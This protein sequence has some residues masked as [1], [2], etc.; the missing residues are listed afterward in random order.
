MS[1]SPVAEDDW[2]WTDEDHSVVIDVLANDIEPDH[3]PLV[4]SSHDVISAHGG[5]VVLNKGGSFDYKPRDGFIG[6]DVFTYT[7]GDGEREFGS[8][9]VNV[10]VGRDLGGI[11]AVELTD[12]NPSEGDLWYGFQT[13][14]Q[15]LVTLWAQDSNDVTITLYDEN[16][17]ELAVW[18]PG[19]GN[20]RL[21]Q[22]APEGQQFYFCLRGTDDGVNVHLANVIKRNTITINGVEYR[23]KPVRT[24]SFTVDGGNDRVVISGSVGDDTLWLYPHSA[25]LIGTGYRI[26]VVNSADITFIGGGGNDRAYLFDS[27]GDDTFVGSATSGTLYGNGFYNS[28]TG[29]D[30]VYAYATQGGYDRAFLYDSAGDD[31]FI[32]TPEYGKLYGNGFWNFAEGFDRVYAYATAGGNDRAFLYDSDGDDTFIGTPDYGKLHGNGFYNYAIDFDRVY[33][34]ATAGGNDRAKFFDS[35]GNDT[36]IGTPTYAKLHGDGFYNYAIDFESAYAYAREGGNDRAKF[37]D[38]AGNDTFVA[39]PDYAKLYGNGFYNYASDFESAY[40]YAREGGNDRAFLYDSA[41][42]DTLVAASSYA[43]FYGSG[44]YNYAT[45]FDLVRAYATRGGSDAK[46]VS[47]VDYVLATYGDHWRRG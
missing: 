31:T 16:L 39:T 14:R 37:F 7:A 10:V 45:G 30:H 47:A 21:E 40:A 19:N 6:T 22:P 27:A 35:A 26:D 20:Q 1:V 11:H 36:F 8:A 24:T 17:N 46:H 9:T 3:D 13:T 33:A 38:S 2:I 5:T 28:V 41:G 43:K 12:L 23:I 18:T 32:G 25:T 29:F 4:I 15:A 42:N 44:F 34:Y